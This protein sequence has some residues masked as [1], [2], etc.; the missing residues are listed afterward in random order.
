MDIT[1]TGNYSIHG[2]TLTIMEYHIDETPEFA[3]GTGE[4]SLRFQYN[5]IID[6]QTMKMIFFKD[7]EYSTQEIIEDYN[8]SFKRLE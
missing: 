7:F 1:T 2:D 6:D 3:G 5:F 8:H 4:L